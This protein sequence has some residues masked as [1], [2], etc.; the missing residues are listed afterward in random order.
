MSDGVE[1]YS[2]RL[3]RLI[4]TVQGDGQAVASVIHRSWRGPEQWDRRAVPSTPLGSPP[5]PPP[6]Y[7]PTVWLVHWAASRLHLRVVQ[8]LAES[9]AIDRRPPNGGPQ[10]G[11]T[12]EGVIGQMELPLGLAP[13]PP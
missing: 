13:P 11:R 7:P 10:G 1:R 2:V 5:A 6:G 4:V 3:A 9:E 12:G 8:H